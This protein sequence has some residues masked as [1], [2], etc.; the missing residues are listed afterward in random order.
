MLPQKQILVVEDNLLNRE[1]LMEILADQYAV[2]GAENGQEALDI[3]KRCGDDKDHVN[4]DLE[5][6]Y[7]D[8]NRIEEE[9]K[10]FEQELLAEH[11]DENRSSV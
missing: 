8:Y 2:L 11:H 4:G 7:E 9:Q 10:Q 6:A 5:R 1:M 3:Q